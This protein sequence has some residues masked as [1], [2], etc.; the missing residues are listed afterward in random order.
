MKRI[1]MGIAALAMASVLTG[2]MPVMSP[3]VGLLVT[4]VYGPIDAGENIGSKEGRA[5]AQSILALVAQ[6]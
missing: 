1:M 4:D 3:A 5:C 2:C 6:G